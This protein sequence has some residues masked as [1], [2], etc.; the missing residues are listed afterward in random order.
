MWSF[1]LWISNV[2][3]LLKRTAYWASMSVYNPGELNTFFL[4]VI[5]T[6]GF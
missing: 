1:M 5:L 3:A 4:T 2:I 6:P